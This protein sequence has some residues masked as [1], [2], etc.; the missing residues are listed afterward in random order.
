MQKTATLIF[1]LF[2]FFQACSPPPAQ[3]NSDTP[4][5]PEYQLPEA[6]NALVGSLNEAHKV[7]TFYQNDVVAFD[8]ELSFGG[9]ERFNGTIYSKTNSSKIKMQRK[10]DKGEVVFDGEEVYIIPD[11]TDWQGA[12]FAVFT[13]QYFFMAPY[14]L[15]DPG[16]NWE[17]TGEKP[18]SSRPYN[19]GK[20]TFSEGTG[21]APDD[22]YLIYQN[23]DTKRLDGMAY[24]VTYGG[25]D[26]TKAE[27]SAHA[28]Y[29]DNWQDL[30]NGI[31][32]A[33]DWDF[34]NWNA[35]EGFN[36]DAIGNAR[37]SNVR[38]F[39]EEGD[40]FKVSESSKK[41]EL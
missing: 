7:A 20:L 33:T 13:W 22:W 10:S 41:V 24:I 37:V 18:I 40:I 35:E 28:I 16:T 23:T 2:S 4:A 3:E 26:A 9:K 36:G 5:T 8:L 12:R 31:P 14:K 1:V 25:R 19:T 6:P 29:Y 32:V 11:T 15:N 17:L 30:R 38:F 27:E 34:Y 21:D 39:A